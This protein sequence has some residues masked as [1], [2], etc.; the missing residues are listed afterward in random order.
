QFLREGARSKELCAY[1]TLSES[2]KELVA[3]AASHGWSL[4]GIQVIELVVSEEE[5]EPDNEYTMFQPAEIELG[6]TMKAILAEVER[7][8]PRRLVID[9]LSEVRLLSQ[10]PLRYRRQVLL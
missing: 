4:D 10:T 3:K 2:K 6:R 5:L 1:V 7:L 9:S 8:K